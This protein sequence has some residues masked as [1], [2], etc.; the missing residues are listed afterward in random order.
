VLGAIKLYGQLGVIAVEID[1]VRTNRVLAA[2]FVRRAAVAKQVPKASFG[3]SGLFAEAART[4]YS[5]LGGPFG[6]VA[7]GWLGRRL[8]LT[9]SLCHRERGLRC[10]P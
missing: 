3:I 8:T 6:K 2:P 9:L 5:R 7:S 1:E 10:A 4:L